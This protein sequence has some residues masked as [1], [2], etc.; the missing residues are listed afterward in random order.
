MNHLE[1]GQFEGSRMNAVE[2]I[3]SNVRPESYLRDLGIEL[4]ELEGK[5]VLGV[6]GMPQGDVAFAAKATGAEFFTVNPGID[7]R[8]YTKPEGAVHTSGLAQE[9]PFADDSFDIELAHAS[10]PGYLPKVES[11][12]RSM[13]SEMLR[14]V[15]PNGEVRIYPIT[16]AM[17]ND[18]VFE[19]IVNG[20]VD[21][22]K[23]E[24]EPLEKRM[25]QGQNQQVYR[26]KITKL[27]KNG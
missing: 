7:Y 22:A 8:D 15:K 5:K 12:Y 13:F 23:F 25:I 2:A 9:L 11:E 27:E 6:G 1:R 14:T 24:F 4:S 3:D 17:Y 18:E 21:D 16:E 19:E 10:V 26:L 20:H